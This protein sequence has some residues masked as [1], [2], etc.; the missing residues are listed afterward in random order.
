MHHRGTTPGSPAYGDL[1]DTVRAACLAEPDLPALI[2]EDGVSC[3]PGPAVVGG[4]LVRGL[5]AA[6]D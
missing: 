3:Y 1:L 4:D 5:P 6:A 2:F